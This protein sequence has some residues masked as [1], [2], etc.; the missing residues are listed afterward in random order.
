[1]FYK[2]DGALTVVLCIATYLITTL[3]CHR[4]TQIWKLL[5]CLFANCYAL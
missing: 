2:L 5:V 3:Y 4:K 1:M